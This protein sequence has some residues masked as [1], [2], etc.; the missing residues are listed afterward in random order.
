MKQ[1]IENQQKNQPAQQSAKHRIFPRKMRT[2]D[3]DAGG[4]HWLGGDPHAT[5]FFNALSAVFP[6]GES[7]MI[8]SLR[9]WQ[10]RVPGQLA[11]DVKNFIQ[12]EAAHSREHAS[13]NRALIR[14]GYDI[15]ALDRAIRK[16]RRVLFGHQRVDQT[17]RDDVHRTSDRDRRI[18]ND[19]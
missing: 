17:G 5:A 3:L 9:P 2:R 8:E 13:M 11:D 4:R 15:T 1:A 16:V 6:R 7:F 18:R 14:S 10:D 12:Q 19:C